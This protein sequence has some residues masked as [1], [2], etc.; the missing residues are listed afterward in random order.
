VFWVTSF[1]YKLFGDNEFTSRIG[2]VFF[3]LSNLI[4]LFFFAKRLFD[5][6][7]AILSMLILGLSFQ[8]LIQ[9]RIIYM[10]V[11]LTFFI[12]L[13]LYFFYLGYHDNRKNY[14]WMGLA[15]GLGTMVK[16]PVALGLPCLIYI[17][18]LGFFKFFKEF[19]YKWTWLAALIYFATV[20]PWHILLYINY[21]QDF[22]NVLFGYHMFERYT[23]VIVSS[24]GPIYY[25]IIMIVVGLF[26]WS[27][28]IPW[29][30][31][32]IK[33]NWQEEKD[34]F[35]F[36]L[37]WFAIIFVFFTIAKT[38][39]PGYIL[40]SYPVFAILI[41]YWWGNIFLDSYPRKKLIISTV[42]ILVIGVLS[43]F[44][45]NNL[46][47]IVERDFNQFIGLYKVL[48]IVPFLSIAGGLII[49][50]IT[51]YSKNY[52]AYI[53]LFIVF[54]LITYISLFI[55]NTSVVPTIDKFKVAK[56]L[57]EVVPKNNEAEFSIASALETRPASLVFYSKR[58]VNY[59]NNLT[60]VKKFMKDEQNYYIYLDKEDYITLKE[61][62]Y[63][64]VLIKEYNNSLIV[65]NK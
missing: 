13:S 25:Y 29:I 15:L 42:S 11:P 65:K 33:N 22:L 45:L 55:F 43:F 63:D 46:R 59:L 31:P 60:E 50:I 35:R 58:R 41:A 54:S 19:R 7:T 39:L 20:L 9:S 53:K 27:V 37:I 5:K 23:D 47:I 4:V 44:G 10:D 16:G 3:G 32:S 38:K 24:G 14:L 17:F 30:Y 40:P 57:A 51:F 36:L 12:S 6:K 1:F 61:Q 26:P 48:Y 2:I 8:Y 21:G 18:Y 34:K 49:L 62:S 56:P 52:K 64:L 28:F